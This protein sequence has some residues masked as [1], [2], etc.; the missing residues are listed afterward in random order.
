[1]SQKECGNSLGGIMAVCE[2]FDKSSNVTPESVQYTKDRYKERQGT[3]Y[4]EEFRYFFLDVTI[5]R[6]QVYM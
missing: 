4:S 5:D 3:Y 2:T 6:L 1:M